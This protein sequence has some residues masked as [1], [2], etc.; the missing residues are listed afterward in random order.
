MLYALVMMCSMHMPIC[1]KFEDI[2]GLYR[3]P[4]VCMVRVEEM[5]TL[6]VRTMG[7]TLAQYGPS[8]KSLGMCGT[9]PKLQS[10]WPSAYEDVGT[11]T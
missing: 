11:R 9:V 7:H 5:R 6:A 4:V 10:R 1:L 2:Q 8:F 3:D